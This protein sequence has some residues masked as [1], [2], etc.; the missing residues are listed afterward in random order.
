[1]ESGM[2]RAQIWTS[3][4]QWRPRPRLSQIV[5]SASIDIAIV[6]INAS[7]RSRCE[8]NADPH[9]TSLRRARKARQA[10]LG[11]GGLR[12]L[13]SCPERRAGR[14]RPSWLFAAGCAAGVVRP[15]GLGP[16]SVLSVMCASLNSHMC[17]GAPRPDQSGAPSLTR[18]ALNHERARRH[19]LQDNETALAESI[20][21]TTQSANAPR[22]NRIDQVLYR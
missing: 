6:V 7:G 12:P 11:V 16:R 5:R 14:L 18:S 19:Q 21:A 10:L 9:G 20:L 15:G 17:S 8:C 2:E 4:P 22:R 1:M 13:H 3:G